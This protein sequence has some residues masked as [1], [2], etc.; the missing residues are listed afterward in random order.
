VTVQTA[1][2]ALFAL[3]SSEFFLLLVR[4]RNWQPDD[5]ERWLADAWKRLL[6]RHP[7]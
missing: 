4:D 3:N 1:A 7:R 5:F 6:L 2:E